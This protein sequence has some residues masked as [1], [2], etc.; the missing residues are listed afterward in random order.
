MT[1]TTYQF[2]NVET[3][4]HL[5]INSLLNSNKT[6][7]VHY[8]FNNIQLLW[9]KGVVKVVWVV[10]KEKKNQSGWA[11]LGKPVNCLCG[12]HSDEEIWG[13]NK[14]MWC[15]LLV[16]H[17]ETRNVHFRVHLDPRNSILSW[18]VP[19]LYCILI[20]IHG[21]KGDFILHILIFHFPVQ[22]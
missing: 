17:K 16:M 14:Y 22:W 7:T 11:N 10:K 5:I 1:G 15:I 2:R 13:V 8:H 21:A 3:V 19:K 6:M 18:F 12:S 20:F 4:K 9:S